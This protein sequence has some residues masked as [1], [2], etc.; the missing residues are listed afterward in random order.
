[1]EQLEVTL[2]LPLGLGFN[3]QNVVSEVLKGGSAAADGR[4]RVGDRVTHVD[5]VE[6]GG[7]RR[8][9]ASCSRTL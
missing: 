4:V 8:K 9:I 3:A 2:P 7:G 5:N 6:V 1:M